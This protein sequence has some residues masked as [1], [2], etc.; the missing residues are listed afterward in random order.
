LDELA[1]LPVEDLALHL[2]TLSGHHLRDPFKNA[3]RLKQVTQESFLLD[4]TLTLPVQRILDLTL[5]HIRFLEAQTTPS[6]TH[7]STEKPLNISIS[8]HWS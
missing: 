2:H 7:A 8:G 6:S 5:D 1:A 3:R 4:E